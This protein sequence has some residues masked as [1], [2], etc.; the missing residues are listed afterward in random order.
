MLFRSKEKKNGG[1]YIVD[2]ITRYNDHP[3][4]DAKFRN[5]NKHYEDAIPLSLDEIT[6]LIY[7][8]DSND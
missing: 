8:G 3:L 1:H 5:N 7:M 2:L 4:S 6:D